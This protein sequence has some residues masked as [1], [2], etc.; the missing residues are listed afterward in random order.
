MTEE[1]LI[2]AEIKKEEED[3]VDTGWARHWTYIGIHNITSNVLK[4]CIVQKEYD[5]EKCIKLILAK[6]PRYYE[7]IFA[8]VRDFPDFIHVEEKVKLLLVLL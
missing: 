5:S 7:R 4:A 6:Y 8:T 2:E 3:Q 1:E